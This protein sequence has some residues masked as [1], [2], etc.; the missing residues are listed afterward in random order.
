MNVGGLLP[1]TM[2]DF[3]G[4]LSAVVFTQGCPLRCPYCHN[5]EL[6]NP[7]IK[8]DVSWE[9]VMDLLK[10]RRPII[11]DAVLINQSLVP[12]KHLFV[13]QDFA[14]PDYGN[15]DNAKRNLA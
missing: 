8:T 7:A 6:Q 4:K 3:P 15:T 5:P 13:L 10:Q 11:F 12:T 1:F 2:I 9:Q 14:I